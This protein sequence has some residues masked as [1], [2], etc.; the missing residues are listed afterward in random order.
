MSI[1][2][3]DR[4]A[5]PSVLILASLAGGDK[6]GYAMMEDI[7]ELSGVRLGPGTLYGALARLEKRGLIRSLESDD[8]RRPYGLTPGGAAAL[9]EYLTGVNKIAA[10]GLQRLVSI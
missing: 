1:A 7:E 4:F 2:D 3:L 8:R 9:K 10:V 6:H 5:D